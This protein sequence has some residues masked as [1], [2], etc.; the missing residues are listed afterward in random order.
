MSRVKPMHLGVRAPTV[1]ITARVMAIPTAMESGRHERAALYR[2]RR[3]RRERDAFLSLY[4]CCACGQAAI[5]VDHRE[6]HQ[7]E[8][9]RVRFWDQSTWQPMCTDCHAKKSALE[10]KAWRDAGEGIPQ[11]RPRR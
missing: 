2:S 4:P 9:W 5:V 6:G 8:D 10:L 1:S 11:S 7:R 3:W